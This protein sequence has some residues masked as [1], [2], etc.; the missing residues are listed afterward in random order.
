MAMTLDELSAAGLI[1]P[2]WAAALEPV[3]PDI[4]ALPQLIRPVMRST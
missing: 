1:D 2:G 4:A 3:A